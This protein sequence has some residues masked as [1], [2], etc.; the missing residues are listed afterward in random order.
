MERTSPR[1]GLI[2]AAIC[3]FLLFSLLLNSYLG[4][5]PAIISDA[6]PGKFHPHYYVANLF[7][8]EGS[9]PAYSEAGVI[10]LQEHLQLILLP[11]MIV[12]ARYG[13]KER[14]TFEMPRV[15][16]LAEQA[17]AME[18]GSVATVARDEEKGGLRVIMSRIIVLSM[19]LFL[20]L[21]S[22]IGAFPGVLFGQFG[23]RLHVAYA[24]MSKLGMDP[25]GPI[26]SDAGLSVSTQDVGIFWILVFLAPIAFRSRQSQDEQPSTP[27]SNLPGVGRNQNRVVNPLLQEVVSSVIGTKEGVNGGA[28]NSAILAMQSIIEENPVQATDVMSSSIEPTFGAI[29][30]T[31]VVGEDV[32]SSQQVENSVPV[33]DFDAQPVETPSFTLDSSADEAI[34]GLRSEDVVPLQGVEDSAPVPD[35]DA[36][37]VDAPSFT[38][39]SSAD[40]AIL[41]LRSEDIT[42]LSDDEDEVTEERNVSVESGIKMPEDDLLDAVEEEP[43]LAAVRVNE[44]PVGNLASHQETVQPKVEAIDT[45]EEKVLVAEQ[46]VRVEPTVELISDSESEEVLA[47]EEPNK[48][49]IVPTVKGVIPVR[50][51]NMPATAEVDPRTGRWMINGV[52]VGAKL[53]A[54]GVA[55]RDESVRVGMDPISE[56][57]KPSEIPSESVLSNEPPAEY[58]ASED[59]EAQ[60]MNTPTKDGQTEPPSL[61]I[62]PEPGSRPVAERPKPRKDEIQLPDMPKF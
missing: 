55:S 56:S 57:K 34:L 39:D 51:A 28:V 11:I 49:D 10:S 60:E 14:A 44:A 3:L 54:T 38:L 46:I 12:V 9:A 58:V 15:A 16:S 37:P 36:Q 59:V 17:E 1:L 22:M 43:L 33:P 13:L 24:V 45:E 2:A 29:E 19:G 35:F 26:W 18:A 8:L 62:T 47:D 50:P 32:V 53:G 5:F 40:E 48:P 23:S 7:G 61:P 21:N 25:S 6:I 4:V 20:L 31:E 52:P 30:S 27:S 41:G 42:V